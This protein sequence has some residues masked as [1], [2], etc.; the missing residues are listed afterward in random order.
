MDCEMPVMDG[1]AATNAIREMEDGFK[2]GR[3]VPIVALT[4]HALPEVR[5]RC[6]AVGMDDYLT[7]PFSLD[8]LRGCVDRCH[9]MRAIGV[10]WD[11]IASPVPQFNEAGMVAA[12]AKS[13][14]GHIEPGEV[15]IAKEWFADDTGTEQLIDPAELNLTDSINNALADEPDDISAKMVNSTAVR[16]ESSVRFETLESIVSLDSA[17]GGGLLSRLISMYEINSAELLQSIQAS[18]EAGDAVALS[19]AAHALKSSSGNVGAE[20]LVKLCKGIELAARNGDLISVGT[21]IEML[22]I[23]QGRVIEMLHDYQPGELA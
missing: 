7:K 21:E 20:R 1:Y 2:D 14:A 3:R 16:D 8:Q 9:E 13:A 5:Q 10:A 23:E 11:A 22:F 6:F 4:A 15:H 12:A 17:N 19:K 18:F